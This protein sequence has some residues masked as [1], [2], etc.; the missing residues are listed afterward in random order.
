VITTDAHGGNIE[1]GE[2]K[3]SP[4]P[5]PYSVQTYVLSALPAAMTSTHVIP[6]RP[7]DDNARRVIHSR[8]DDVDS[9][10]TI[11]VVIRT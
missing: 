6:V 2:A 4:V 7:N 8:R 11:A 5:P 3:V 9:G 10:R 1:R